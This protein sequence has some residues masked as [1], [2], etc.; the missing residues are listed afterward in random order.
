MKVSP[1]H[2]LPRY[3]A[4]TG[5][6]VTALNR[7]RETLKEEYRLSGIPHDCSHS[8]PISAMN[9]KIHFI[10]IYEQDSTALGGQAWS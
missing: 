5:N 7:H 10:L 4:S 6:G 1:A 9:D 2:N 3:R 8:L